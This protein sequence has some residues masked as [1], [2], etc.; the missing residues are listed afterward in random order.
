MPVT[1]HDDLL[2]E[3]LGKARWQQYA[4]DPRRRDVA[5]LLTEAAAA[6]RDMN[7]LL[8]EAVT[9]RD[10]EDDQKSPSRRV[11]SVLHYRIT[12]LLNEEPKD[13]TSSLPADVAGLLSNSTAPAGIGPKNPSRAD[14]A[15]Q[16]PP[17]S[18]AHGRPSD[19]RDSR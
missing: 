17:P 16:A 7:E 4:D 19:G 13:G 9:M 11:A 2:Q 6:N 3:L 10:W 12:G 15:S 18:R 14:P 8:T 1:P 5:K